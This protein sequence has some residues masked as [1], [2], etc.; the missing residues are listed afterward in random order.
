MQLYSFFNLGTRLGWV[1]RITLRPFYP[2]R[3]R[4]STH[5]TGG[6]LGLRVRRQVLKNLASIWFESR[7]FQLQRGAV[8]TALSRP[9]IRFKS[10]KEYIIKA[11][12][13]NSLKIVAYLRIIFAFAAQRTN[14]LQRM[15]LKI[16]LHGDFRCLF[17][18]LHIIAIVC[19]PQ[20]INNLISSNFI[21]IT[22]LLTNLCKI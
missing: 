2:R 10:P 22:R 20:C 17:F 3:K 14:N 8:P 1:V 15:E 13:S 16:L 4:S 18:L 21:A 9:R 7:M 11:L 6:R 12:I 5:C 19:T